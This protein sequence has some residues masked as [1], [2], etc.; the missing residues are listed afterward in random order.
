[1]VSEDG[2]LAV[3]M[4]LWD[5]DAAIP[6]RDSVEMAGSFA[7]QVAVILVLARARQAHEQLVVVEERDRIARDLHDLVIQRLFATGM[8]L[9]GTSR[10]AVLE[11]AV[12][13]RLSKAVD[14][15]DETIREIRQTIFALHEPMDGSDAS[16]RGRVLREAEQSAASL[17]FEPSVRFIGAVDT[18]VPDSVSEHLV[19]AL[20][21][22][23]AN[24]AKHADARQVDVT[25][26]AAG[27]EV[28]LVVEDDGVGLSMNGAS[29]L[30]GVA[31]LRTRAADLGGTCEIGR[32]SDEGGTRLEWRVPLV[33]A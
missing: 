4:L 25:L 12:E 27:T 6:G 32:L 30:S 14:E 1:M 2:V 23:L 22:A 11:E 26:Q 15:L 17:G 29:R 33:E 18:L 8:M 13:Q 3:L 16:L 24:A 9:Q 20:R 31:N 19:A 10:I 5:E 7:A 21:E 28:T